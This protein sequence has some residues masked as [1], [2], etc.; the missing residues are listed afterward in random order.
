MKPYLQNNDKKL[1]YKYLD[2]SSIY[3]EYGSG[4]STFQA[5]FR[6]NIQKIYSVESDL[7]W[8]TKMKSFLKHTKNIHFILNEINI[9]ST[10]LEHPTSTSNRNEDSWRKYSNQLGCLHEEER[11][12]IDLVMIDGL[13]RVACCLKCFDMI[14]DDCFIVFDDFLNKHEYHMVLYFYDI[15]E[16]TSDHRMVVLKKK[17]SIQSIPEEWIKKYETIK[18]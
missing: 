16:K 2:T 9:H 15:V 11:K 7:E 18:D 3:F 10:T 4:G 17:Q 12:Q 14:R 13:F 8:H 5:S 1:F 6:N